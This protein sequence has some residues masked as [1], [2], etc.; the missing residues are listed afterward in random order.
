MLATII[1]IIISRSPVFSAVSSKISA[2]CWTH[3]D[4]GT[5]VHS[6]P[7]LPCHNAGPSLGGAPLFKKSAA[8]I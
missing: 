7:L 1:I 5:R 8:L 6:S 3:L 4:S 2:I